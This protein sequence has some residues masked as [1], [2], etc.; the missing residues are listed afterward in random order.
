MLFGDC[1]I[2]LAYSLMVMSYPH[3]V[4]NIFPIMFSII[5]AGAVVRLTVPRHLL[6]FAVYPSFLVNALSTQGA[7]PLHRVAP[8]FAFPS[9]LSLWIVI[10]SPFGSFYTVLLLVLVGS[11]ALSGVCRWCESVSPGVVFE[12]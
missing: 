3:E 5:T 8:H 1:L 11:E 2:T 9:P 6:Q 12:V 10:L 7:P 4:W